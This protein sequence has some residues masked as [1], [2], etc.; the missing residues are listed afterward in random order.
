MVAA[1]VF[2]VRG[3]TSE[4]SGA[5]VT[6]DTV[7]FAEVCWAGFATGF[8][9]TAVLLEAFERS[10]DFAGAEVFVLSLALFV[11]VAFEA[12]ADFSF[13]SVSSSVALTFYTGFS[14]F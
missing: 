10:V 1:G 6:S 7:D 14:F 4:V 5:L 3:V 8:S 13:S 12:S 2:P 9:C 11:S